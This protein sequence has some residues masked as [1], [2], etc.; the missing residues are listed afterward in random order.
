LGNRLSQPVKASAIASACGLVL[1]GSDMLCSHVEPLSQVTPGGLCFSKAGEFENVQAG[2]LVIAPLGADACVATVL[3]AERP[4]LAFAKVLNMIAQTVGF[5]CETAPPVIHPTAVVSPR[6]F[7]GNG[8]HIGA[9]TI[10]NHFAVIGDGVQIGDDCVIKSG[11]VIGEDGFGF[12]RDEQGI[13]IRLV[14]L[15][16]VLIGNGVEIGSLTT[17]CRGTLANTVIDDF[18]KIDDHVHIAHNCKIGTGAMVVACAEVSGGVVLGS[19]TWVG[20][21]ASII[22]QL[23]VGDDALIGIGANVLRDV[24]PGVTV[25]GNPAKPLA[26]RP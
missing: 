9:R 16:T 10:V 18:A 8:V 13:P 17:V 5:Q 19:R 14:H 26:P 21:N 23:T 20:P 25:A 11:A 15:G 7:I 4:R 1:R 6:A 12:E 22:Q 2:C 3:E 24:L